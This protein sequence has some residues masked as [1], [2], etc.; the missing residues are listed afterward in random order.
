MQAERPCG[1]AGAARM[2][3]D[4]DRDRPSIGAE[5]VEWLGKKAT[6]GGG[7][8]SAEPEGILSRGVLERAPAPA[9]TSR[10]A[11]S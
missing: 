11:S 9:A 8:L 1:P 7:L 10:P 2:T 4:S 5:L 3:P 6:V